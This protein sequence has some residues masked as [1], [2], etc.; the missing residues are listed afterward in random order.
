[1]SALFPAE[2]LTIQAPEPGADVAYTPPPVARAVVEVLRPELVGATVWEPYAGG[3]AFVDALRDGGAGIVYATE[4][5]PLATGVHRADVG[6]T[7]WDVTRGWPWTA[8]KPDAIVTNPPFSELDEHLPILLATAQRLV[9]LLLVG[10]SV[11]PACRDWMWETALFD[12]QLWSRERIP[13]EGPGRNGAN[14]DMREYAALVWRKQPDGSWMG[15]G[16][17]GRFSWHQPGKIWRGVSNG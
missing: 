5:D 13:F 10:Q 17:S 14:T 6:L 1:M 16:L 7:P 8:A 9:C 3:G 11:A 15:R 12:E 4:A 2:L